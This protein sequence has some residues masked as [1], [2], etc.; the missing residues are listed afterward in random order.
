M[1][2]VL[3]VS[4]FLFA[5][6]LA[7]LFISP[8]S[9]FHSAARQIAS[10]NYQLRVEIENTDE[11]SQLASSFNQMTLG[12]AQREKMRRFV[13]EDL[14]EQLGQ[15][16]VSAE[17]RI[18]QVTLLASDIRRF[19]ALSEKYEP[20]QIVNLL[21]DY[22]TE[23]ETAITSCGGFIERLVGDAVVA[24]F[25]QSGGQQSEQQAAFAA[26][27][28]R[29]RLFKLNQQRSAVGL[30]T[31]ENGIGIATG[32]AFSGMAGVESGRRIFSV[33]GEVSRRAEKIEAASRFVES[34]ILLCKYT[35]EKLDQRFKVTDATRQCGLAAYTL[36]DC[37]ET[38]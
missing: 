3:F 36:I 9:G 31:I 37:E 8:V 15:Q 33:I 26:W 5:D 30:F 21:N 27:R 2:V 17:P 10:G 18:S 24:V 29:A 32:Q 28:M 12:L 7:V 19:T 14:Y 25:Y 22:F 13:S 6:I 38:T 34:R 1:F 23:M 16:S 35:A 20:Q 4:L 11:F